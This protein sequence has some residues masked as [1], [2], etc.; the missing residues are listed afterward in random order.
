MGESTVLNNRIREDTISK[1]FA[2]RLNLAVVLFCFRASFVVVSVEKET[3]TNRSSAPRALQIA[4]DTQGKKANVQVGSSQRLQ[5]GKA[6][7]AG[8]DACRH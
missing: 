8:N 3:K 5:P 2:V 1:F 6:T 7:A 4:S